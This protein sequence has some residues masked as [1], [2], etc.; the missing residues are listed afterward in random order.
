LKS[1]GKKRKKRRIDPADLAFWQLKRA[2][3]GEA[4]ESDEAVER[5]VRRAQ[6]R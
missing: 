2:Q 3:R 1:N 6:G 4:A 5:K